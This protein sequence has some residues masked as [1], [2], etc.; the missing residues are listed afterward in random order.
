MSQAEM[1][2]RMNIACGAV[3]LVGGSLLEA[4]LG[5]TVSV[6]AAAAFMAQHPDAARDVVMFC[7][8]GAIG[9][10]FIFALIRGF[11]SLMNT[12]ATTCRK[13]RAVQSVARARC[14]CV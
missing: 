8:S 9:Q 4:L 6:P 13:V 10:M 12:C 7:L 3:L 5:H 1:M 14:S 11:G 2:L